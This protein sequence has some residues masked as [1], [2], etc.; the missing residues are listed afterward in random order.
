MHLA[1]ARGAHVIATAGPDHQDFVA[2][3]G[4]SPTNDSP[5]LVQQIAAP[6]PQGVDAAADLTGENSLPDLVTITGD[7]DKVVP[8]ADLPTPRRR[9][10]CPTAG[11]AK[12]PTAAAAWPP[13]PNSSP[14]GI[15]ASR[16]APPIPARSSHHDE[17][18]RGKAG[19]TTASLPAQATEVWG[20]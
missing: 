5:D 6:V 18:P 15:S 20:T 4:A 16:C 2:D 12:D 14:G 13:R 11:P 8:I 19:H 9:C 1:T 7:P 17:Q 3:L 10:G